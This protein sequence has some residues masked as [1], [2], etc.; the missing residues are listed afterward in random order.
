[1]A[2][3][4]R[5]SSS[6]TVAIPKAK[7]A[8]PE[9]ALASTAKP[10]G[11]PPKAKAAE[12]EEVPAPTAKPRGRPPK[13][14]NKGPGRPKGVTKA[15]TTKRKAAVPTPATKRGGVI[16]KLD[17]ARPDVDIKERAPPGFTKDGKVKATVLMHQFLNAHRPALAHLT[18][19]EQRKKLFEMWHVAPENPKN[20][21]GGAGE[22]SSG[23]DKQEVGTVSSA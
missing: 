10:R 9:E 12:S 15:T 13:A 18:T 21:A 19:G 8:E 22:G 2:K 20:A 5:K 17:S 14:L 1:M 11:R 7:A 3:T 16:S 4:V 23:S 6:A